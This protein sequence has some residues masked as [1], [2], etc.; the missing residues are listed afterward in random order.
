MLHVLLYNLQHSVQQHTAPAW[1][2]PGSPLE[3]AAQEGMK[4]CICVCVVDTTV[5]GLMRWGGA[6]WWACWLALLTRSGALALCIHL[7]CS[8]D[9]REE[10]GAGGGVG[11]E[12]LTPPLGA[13]MRQAC[14]LVARVCH[15]VWDRADSMHALEGNVLDLDA[16]IGCPQIIPCPA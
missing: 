3:G 5:H 7:F 10:A 16:G 6:Y 13:D 1:V 15:S 4:V 11:W 8:E 9:G 14:V 2:L 12:H